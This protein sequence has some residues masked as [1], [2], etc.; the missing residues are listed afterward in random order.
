MKCKYC[1]I[2]FEQDRPNQFYCTIKCS[3]KRWYYDNQDKSS[4][5]REKE[6][7]NPEKQM[8]Q[9]VKSR[10]KIDGIPFNIE[11]SDIQIPDVCPVLGVTLV[12]R[13]GMKGY[14]KYAPSLDKIQPELGYVK[15]N[16]R[17]ISARANLLKSD[18]LL[19]ELELVV[20]DLKGLRDAGRFTGC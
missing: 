7:L 17:V 19:S 2:E 11:L 13:L 18:A 9:R 12:R 1:D 20:N 10:A 15:G 5:K 16:V 8:Y 3:Y 14:S 6:R 4:I